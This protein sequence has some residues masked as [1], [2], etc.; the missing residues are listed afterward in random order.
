MRASFQD[1]A[2]VLV[3]I[4]HHTKRDFTNY[5]VRA[6]SP[7]RPKPNQFEALSATLEK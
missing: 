3:L 7:Q 6:P 4:L 5:Y 1:S 2:S